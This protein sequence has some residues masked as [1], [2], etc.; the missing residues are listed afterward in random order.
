MRLD[1]DHNRNIDLGNDFYHQ[2]P[3][4]NYRHPANHDYRYIL[5]AHYDNFHT[6]RIYNYAANYDHAD[7]D[8]HFHDNL[9]SHANIDK[10]L[11]DYIDADIN[12]AR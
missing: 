1:G 9:S 12:C 5:A 4:H 3:C 7:L 11:C 10:L 6:A 8:R 2:L